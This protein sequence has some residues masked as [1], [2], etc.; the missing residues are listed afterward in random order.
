M[1]RE[2]LSVSAARRLIH[3]ITAL[4]DNL[5]LGTLKTAGR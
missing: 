3:G 2:A 1:P 4:V 5:T